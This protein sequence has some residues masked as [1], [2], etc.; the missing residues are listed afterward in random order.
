[1]T[2]TTNQIWQPLTINPTVRFYRVTQLDTDGPQV[3]PMSPTDGSIAVNQKATLTASLV[4]ETGINTNTISLQIST[5][6]PVT[7]TDSRLGFAGGAL[8]YIL[9]TNEVL[10]LP[11]SNVTVRVSATD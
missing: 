9:G 6:A 7:L 3:I 5:N 10:G 11:G 8:T 4:D 2:A 1:I